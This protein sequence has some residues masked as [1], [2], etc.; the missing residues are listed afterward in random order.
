MLKSIK[1]NLLILTF[2]CV[3]Y[4][5][6]SAQQVNTLYFMDNVPFR[7]TLNPAFQPI[8]D[9]YVGLPVVG[10]TQLSIGNNSVALKDVIY[11]YNGQTVS[12]LHPDGGTIDKFFHTLHSTGLITT[13]FE[14]NLLS[15]GFRHKT[16][17]WSFTLTEKFQSFI[18]IP[19]DA[20]NLALYGTPLLFDNKFNLTKLETDESLYTE[21]AL[22]Y[23]KVLN[24]KWS[25]G[26]K[27]KYLFGSANFSNSNTMIKMNAGIDEW[28]LV[29]G[30]NAYYSSPV[31]VSIASNFRSMTYS[32]PATTNDWLK[33]SGAGTGIDLG[34]TYAATPRL[35]FSA[36]LLDLG[37]IHWKKN[38][39]MVNYKTDYTFDGVR[40]IDLSSSNLNISGSLNSLAD[41]IV[42]ALDSASTYASSNK[43]YTTFTPAILNMGVEYTFLDKKM[44]VGL[45]S[46]SQ[47]FKNII[48]EEVTLSV[49]ARPS[50][51]FNASLSTSFFEGRFESI[52]AGVGLRT[53]FVHW[54]LAADYIPFQRSAYQG[55]PIPYT[56]KT[57][58]LALGVQL[59][60][61]K[62]VP[63]FG[64][65]KIATKKACNCL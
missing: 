16:A 51:R 5:P 49:N 40:G 44:S 30:G 55:I 28:T 52:G 20:F 60:F 13:S 46:R 38:A 48:S 53:G 9:V 15:F 36:A 34:V 37:F 10:L 24:K 56:T 1:R 61:D 45:L 3:M 27:L 35:T 4:S 59:V 63:R 6:A 32:L 26:A 22:G 7:H 17:F 2:F 18:A 39:L 43:P 64:L 54:T 62:I 12:F 21:A 14:T 8:Q 29:G 23:A 19:K 11:K 57:F 25:V 33:R 42:A 50:D 58:N 47:F 65:H 31:A 41:S